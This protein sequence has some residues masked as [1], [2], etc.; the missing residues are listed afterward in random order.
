MVKHRG[1]GARVCRTEFALEVA[2]PIATSSAIGGKYLP[3]GISVR[4]E[5]GNIKELKI[6][7]T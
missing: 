3:H 7:S 2:L 5:R 1:F 6:M 4:I